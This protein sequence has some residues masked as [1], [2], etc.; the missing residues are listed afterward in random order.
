MS[1]REDAELD[2]LHF[3]EVEKV[4]LFV[5]DARQRAERAADALARSGAAEHL[6]IAVRQSEASLADAHRLLMQRTY[7]HVGDD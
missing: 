4:L 3:A 7:F 5:S 1:D 2:E 6:I